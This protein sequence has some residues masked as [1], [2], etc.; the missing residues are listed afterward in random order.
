MNVRTRAIENYARNEARR[1]MFLPPLFVIGEP[2]WGWEKK[3][4]GKRVTELRF[5]CVIACYMV[6]AKRIVNGTRSNRAHQHGRGCKL[7]RQYTARHANN[8][9]L[10]ITGHLRRG[11]IL[12]YLY[13]SRRIR[14][15]NQDT[16][17]ALFCLFHLPSLTAKML[18]NKKSSLVTKIWYY[19]PPDTLILRT[20]LIKTRTRNMLCSSSDTRPHSLLARLE[21]T[22]G[23][24]PGFQ[25]LRVVGF[26]CFKKRPRSPNAIRSN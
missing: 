5:I 10:S 20:R 19:Q 4:K 12:R 3:E 17:S 2:S 16:Y 24:S 6:C 26:F 13:F 14:S 21:A 8:V 23:L 22:K 15:K 25:N 9:A 11:N 7:L 1:E 18:F